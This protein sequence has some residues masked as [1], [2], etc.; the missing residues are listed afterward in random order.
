MDVPA[1]ETYLQLS[2]VETDSHSQSS[3]GE[4]EEEQSSCAA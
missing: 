1:P 2:V 3:A 4:S